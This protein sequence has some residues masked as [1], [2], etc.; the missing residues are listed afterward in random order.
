M[1][2]SIISDENIK[3]KVFNECI[4]SHKLQTTEN[5]YCWYGVLTSNASGFNLHLTSLTNKLC[6]NGYFR[7]KA[8]VI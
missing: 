8:A 3:K 1:F 7:S 5:D 2:L 4:L 6:D